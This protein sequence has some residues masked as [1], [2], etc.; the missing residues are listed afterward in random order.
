MSGEQEKLTGLSKIFNGNTMS[1]RA[2]VSG[3][4]PTSNII[5]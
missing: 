5:D 3:V 1:G 2:N 4:H